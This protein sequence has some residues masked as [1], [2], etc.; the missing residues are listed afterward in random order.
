[1]N[2]CGQTVML[3][4][5][6][7]SELDRIAST[8]NSKDAEVLT[9]I[10]I[11]L[12]RRYYKCNSIRVHYQSAINGIKEYSEENDTDSKPA[13]TYNILQRMKALLGELDD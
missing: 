4:I 5:S 12:D 10:I 11:N 1:M 2:I 3:G 13:N 7:G 8:L 6:D 9:G